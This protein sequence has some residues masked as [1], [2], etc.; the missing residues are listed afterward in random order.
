MAVVAFL[1]TEDSLNPFANSIALATSPF[2]IEPPS[3]GAKWVSHVAAKLASTA[4]PL[5]LVFN[6]PTSIHAPA[7]GFSRKSLRRP[8][9]AYVLVDPVMPQVGGEYGD[10]PDAPVT[11]V[12]TDSAS[13]SAKEASMQS[14]LRGWTVTNALDAVL[15]NY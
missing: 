10:W 2:V 4:E 6:G 9:V 11:V 3:L 12:I 5:V 14:R 1:P 7:I 8:A 13:E 15:K